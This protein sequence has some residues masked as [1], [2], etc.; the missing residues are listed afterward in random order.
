MGVPLCSPHTDHICVCPLF[1]QRRVLGTLLGVAVPALQTLLGLV[2]VLRLP[3]VVGT[4]G[5][6]QACAIGLLLSA[7]VSGVRGHI[8]GQRV[9]CG[10]MAG[11]GG[12]GAGLHLGHV[13]FGVMSGCVWGQGSHLGLCVVVRSHVLGSCVGWGSCLG[14]HVGSGVIFGASC[15]VRGRVLGSCVGGG[16]CL[17]H[18]LGQGSR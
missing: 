17:P 11:V 16:S 8:W 2:L 9:I 14:L 3:W 10:V 12:P 13:W 7:C 4:G 5:V 6:L 15:E 1:T 18:M